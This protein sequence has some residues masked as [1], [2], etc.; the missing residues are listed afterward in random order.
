MSILISF[1]L[2]PF[3]FCWGRGIGK[4]LKIELYTV[5]KAK[6]W[7]THLREKIGK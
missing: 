5:H 1:S 6:E 7:E 3:R 4:G 2:E